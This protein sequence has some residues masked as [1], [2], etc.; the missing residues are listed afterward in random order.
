VAALLFV[1]GLLLGSSVVAQRQLTFD[2]FPHLVALREFTAGRTP[3]TEAVMQDIQRG[4]YGRLAEPGEDLHRISYP[5]YA[6]VLLAP[7]R[8]LDYT[9]AITLWMALQL[10]AAFLALCLWSALERRLTVG[11]VIVSLVLALTYRTTITIF[12]N[13]QFNALLLA[14]Y[15]AGILLLARRRDLWAGG[16][17]ALSALQ[18]TLMG[19]LGFLQLVGLAVRGRWRGLAVWA[20]VLLVLTAFTIVVIGWW[21]PD[22]LTALTGYS[23]YQRFLV[24]VPER[25]GILWAGVGLLCIAIPLLRP[26]SL[27]DSYALTVVGLLLVLPQTGVYYLIALL[28]ILLIALQRA[29]KRPPLRHWGTVCLTVAFL[30]ASW[31]FMALDF[32]AAKIESLILPLAALLI[33]AVASGVTSRPASSSPSAAASA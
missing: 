12:L 28:P 17:M 1:A 22:W 31:A 29:Q 20:G 30:G 4:Y 26:L 13:A 32:E 18:P 33:L 14:V 23:S 5:A 6:Y 8:P 2:I 21:L 24:W 25:F 11:W 15:S 16:V 19:P 27:A 3:Y 7:L 10:P 9:A